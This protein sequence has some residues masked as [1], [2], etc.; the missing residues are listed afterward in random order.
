VKSVSSGQLPE[1]IEKVRQPY[2]G[3]TFSFTGRRKGARNVKQA[4]AGLRVFRPFELQ[5]RGCMDNVILI[6]I[7]LY[8]HKKFWKH[9]HKDSTI[10]LALVTSGKRNGNFT[11]AGSDYS[12]VQQ[13]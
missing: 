10:V 7:S 3:V 9:F 4:R 1:K 2:D 12:S 13:G 6:S 8:F 11:R 5:G